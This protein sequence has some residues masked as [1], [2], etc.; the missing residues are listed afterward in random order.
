VFDAELGWIRRP[1]AAPEP[2][3]SASG[4]PILFSGDSYVADIPERLGRLRPQ[5]PAFD[6]GVGGYGI[7]QTFLRLRREYPL[8]EASHPRVLFGI[9]LYDLDRCLLKFRAGQKPWFEELD[10]EAHLMLPVSPDNDAFVE[11]YPLG[12]RFFVWSAIRGVFRSFGDHARGDPERR[13][14][15]AYLVLREVRREVLLKDMELTI[16]VFYNRPALE[17]IMMGAVP[18]RERELNEI[19]TDLGFEGVVR[20]SDVLLEVL[21]E[22]DL[23]PRDLYL[24]SD[25]PNRGHHTAAANE[26]I[27]EWLVGSL[28]LD[29]E[30]G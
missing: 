5:N 21:E 18:T 16:V 12:N 19:L 7:D 14:R 25:H 3:P 26:L 11:D 22:R 1:A 23:S 30:P 6:F 24:P 2:G 29:G 10:G 8:F 20:T 27:A 15:L 13:R 9:F 17:Q 4:R 28:N